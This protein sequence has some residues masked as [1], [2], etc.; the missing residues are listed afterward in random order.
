[1]V[2]LSGGTSEWYEC[3]NTCFPVSRDCENR[4]GY[5]VVMGGSVFSVMVGGSAGG[6]GVGARRSSMDHRCSGKGYGMRRVLVLSAVAAITLSG[7][8]AGQAAAGER[9]PHYVNRASGKCLEATPE[10]PVRVAACEKG[11]EA[12]MWPGWGTT[13]VNLGNEFCLDTDREGAV[14]TRQCDGGRSQGWQFARGHL[15]DQASGGCLAVSR[16]EEV[17]VVRCA[18]ADSQEWKPV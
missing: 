18:G 7:V 2:S 9:F 3:I 5:A 12:Q 17:R 6:W 16:S 1:M 8:I 15:R 13:L 14:F 10:G 4:C 11:N